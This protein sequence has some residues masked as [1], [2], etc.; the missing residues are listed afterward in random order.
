MRHNCRRFEKENRRSERKIF[1][2]A[3]CMLSFM[4]RFTQNSI[5][6]LSLRLTQCIL[7]YSG[8]FIAMQCTASGINETLFYLFVN[9]KVK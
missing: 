8:I 4:Q 7:W 3:G 9:R 1:R 5:D 6:L 2:R